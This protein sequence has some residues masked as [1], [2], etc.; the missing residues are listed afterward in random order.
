MESVLGELRTATEWRAEN[1]WIIAGEKAIHRNKEGV[2]L[3]AKDQVCFR[4][5]RYYPN[6]SRK[7]DGEHNDPDWEGGSDYGAGE[8]S[9][10]GHCGDPG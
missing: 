1:F 5:P 6:Y 4:M 8:C 7:G 2:A 9:M 10:W 3:F